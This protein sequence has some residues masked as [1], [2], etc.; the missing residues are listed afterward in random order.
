[1]HCEYNFKR[2]WRSSW[3]ISLFRRVGYLPAQ[4]SAQPAIPSNVSSIL[5]Q[6]DVIDN[7]PSAP[8]WDFVWNALVEEGRERGMLSLPFTSQQDELSLEETSAEEMCLAEAALKVS[9]HYSA[10]VFS[11]LIV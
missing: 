9:L 10:L 4:Q 1:M 11:L 7:P 6:F 2:W 3:L 5:E 8:S